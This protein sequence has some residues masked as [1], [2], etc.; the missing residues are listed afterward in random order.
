MLSHLTV[1]VDVERY[2]LLRETVEHLVMV[3]ILMNVLV[4]ARSDAGDDVPVIAADR[5]ATYTV[6]DVVPD[7]LRPAV[8][9]TSLRAPLP[10]VIQGQ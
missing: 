6:A 7:I 1:T 3:V 10:A 2:V 5:L 9:M 8:M 4:M